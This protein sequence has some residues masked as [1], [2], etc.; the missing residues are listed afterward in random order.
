MSSNAVSST[1][2]ALLNRARAK[3]VDSA[4]NDILAALS[5]FPDLAPD[6]EQFVYP[7]RTRALTF[8]LKGTIPVLYK[9]LFFF[10]V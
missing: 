3:Y 9:V 7:D 1:V 4:K 6:V 5:G 10:F 2:V 8:R